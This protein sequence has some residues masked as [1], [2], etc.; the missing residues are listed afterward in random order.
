MILYD[1]ANGRVSRPYLV[2]I[3]IAMGRDTGGGGEGV[4]EVQNRNK[5][6]IEIYIILFYY[7]FYL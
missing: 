1:K 7:L 2:S 6:Q 4:R 5:N 3:F